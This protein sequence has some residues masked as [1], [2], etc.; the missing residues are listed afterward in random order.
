MIAK[1]NDILK[2]MDEIVPPGLSEVWD[3][4]GLQVGDVTKTVKKIWISLDPSHDVV[5][6]ACSNDVDLLI[7]HHP[8]IFSP[9]K[10]IRSDSVVGSIIK[11]CFKHDLTIFAAHTNYD[12]VEGG[13]NDILAGKI[14]LQDLSIFKSTQPTNASESGTCKIV[15]FT[16]ESHKDSILNALFESGCGLIGNYSCC[17]FYNSGTGTYMPGKNSKPYAGKTGEMTYA[18]EMRIESIVKTNQVDR[19]IRY[20]K[21]R[22]PYEEMAYDVYPLAG[23]YT[24]SGI[25]RVGMLKKPLTLKAFAELVKNNLNLDTLKIAG[26]ENLQVERVAVCSGSGSSLLKEFVKSGADAYVSG[27]LKHHDAKLIEDEDLGL[28]DIGHFSSEHLAL[29]R[30]RIMLQERCKKSKFN[31]EIGDCDLEKDPFTYL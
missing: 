28:V 8:L 4:S 14:G 21:E 12:I 15:I 27:D 7:T 6:S 3:N 20:V 29:E 11:L 9:L 23:N 30:L 13:V 26:R 2:I 24:S 17:S 16:P 22:H 19:V 25:G 5:K 18:D 31:I 10:S 1:V